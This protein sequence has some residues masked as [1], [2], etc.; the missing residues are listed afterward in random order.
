M[1]YCTNCKT[2]NEV[3]AT[4]CKNCGTNLNYP[5]ASL[6]EPEKAL[7]SLIIMSLCYPIIAIVLYIMEKDKIGKKEAR[8]YLIS[9]IIAIILAVIGIALTF[10]FFFAMAST[11]SFI[12]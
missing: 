5:G 12:N 11:L 3:D 4:F 7:L 9:C 1:T 8:K 10:L 2:E 6:R